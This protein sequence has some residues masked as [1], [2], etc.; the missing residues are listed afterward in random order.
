MYVRTALSLIKNSTVSG[1]LNNLKRNHIKLLDNVM[2]LIQEREEEK[3]DR[4]I[5]MQ[6]IL[7][8]RDEIRLIVSS[9]FFYFFSKNNFF[10]FQQ[11][12]KKTETVSVTEMFPVSTQKQLWDFLDDADGLFKARCNGFFDYVSLIRAD[13]M[14]TYA[15][16]LLTHIFKQEYIESH[17]WPSMQ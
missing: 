12:N 7:D 4:R 1:S 11:T 14:K 13:N 10:F 17:H 15:D 3:R 5:C 2:H 8:L 6:M 9:Y 16:A